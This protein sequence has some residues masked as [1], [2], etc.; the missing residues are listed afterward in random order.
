MRVGTLEVDF[1]IPG[2]DSLKAKRKVMS[3][4]RDRIRARFPVAVAEVGHQELYA[5]GLLG[6]AA[7]GGNGGLVERAL[8]E[9]VRLIESDVR[10]LIVDVVRETH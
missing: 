9:I 7:V 4:L 5:R 6:V 3:S 2:S 10:V 8:D 1:R